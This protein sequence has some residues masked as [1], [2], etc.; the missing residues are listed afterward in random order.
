ML[1]LRLVID[2][3]FIEGLIDEKEEES[4]I[5]EYKSSL[6]IGTRTDHKELCK[7]VT[8]FANAAGGLIL[9]GIEEETDENGKPTGKPKE[10][11]G[12]GEMNADTEILRVQEI[13]L[14]GIDPRLTPPAHITAYRVKGKQVIALRVYRSWSSPHM[15]TYGGL[16]FLG[17]CKPVKATA[18]REWNW[19]SILGHFGTNKSH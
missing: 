19:R 15:I 16:A 9:Y 1:E 18:R 7:D 14:R 13:L 6:Q 12:L 3:P 10:V 17:A 8:A 2:A 5:L 4:K 11:C